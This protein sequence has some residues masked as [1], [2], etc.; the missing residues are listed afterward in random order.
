[1]KNPLAKLAL[2]LSAAAALTAQQGGSA[3]A[4]L[5]QPD[6]PAAGD[7]LGSALGE[8]S[9]DINRDPPAYLSG[10][11]VMSDGNPPPPHTQ[12]E[13]FCYGFRRFV[14]TVTGKGEFDLDLS[15]RGMGAF[16]A[17]MRSQNSGGLPQR[18]ALGI[19]NL[20]GCLVRAELPG[21]SSTQIELAMHSIFDSPNIGEILLTP[22]EGVTGSAVSASSLNAP[23]KAQTAFLKARSENLK[24]KPNLKKMERSLQTAVGQ[25]GD[26][27][28]AWDLLGRTQ[29]GLG[30]QAAA[31]AS[32]ERA[33]AV[34]PLF[35]RP[36]TQLVPLLAQ[37]GDLEQTAAVGLK[38]LE[39]NPHD[40]QTR[41]YVA[42]A[43]LR[44]GRSEDAAA[45]ARELIARG[46]DEYPQA[47]QLHG[48]ALANL[49]KYAEAARNYRR[50][51]RASPQATAADNI[52]AQ[53][54]EWEQ[55][56]V[57]PPAEAEAAADQP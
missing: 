27:A 13:L 50:F 49:G 24:K 21:Y 22:L 14:D 52:R 6:A 36:Y 54:A 5:T 51:L 46:A 30:K 40:N 15:G 35:I 16:D 3:R 7:P 29:L 18:S 43:Q 57:T 17:G 20:N 2:M 19:V 32:F 55:L 48:G 42:V 34:D 28:E 31:R 12:V 10:K 4:P 33:V 8:R 44:L 37:T 56:G 26:Y 11:V 53:L 23:K 45:S 41:F 1:M 9:P 25:F 47:Y 39:L 38:A